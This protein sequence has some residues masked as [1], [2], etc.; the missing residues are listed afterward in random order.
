[1][2][3]VHALST[4]APGALLCETSP[5]LHA[6]PS[7]EGR[8]A[9]SRATR[10]SMQFRVRETARPDAMVMRGADRRRGT[11]PGLH[12]WPSVEGR[13]APTGF[14]PV[15]GGFADL[16]LRPLGYG[17]LRS[18]RSRQ[19]FAYG[20]RARAR[21][22]RASSFA[23]RNVHMLALR[24]HQ[25]SKTGRGCKDSR[26]QRGARGPKTGRP[27]PTRW[28]RRARTPRS[29][30][31]RARRPRIVHRRRESPRSGRWLRLR[32]NCR[33]R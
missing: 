11:S 2:R 28:S 29:P 23:A 33:C 15:N 10:S 21:F 31:R 17:A 5:G 24:D 25:G 9:R 4:R 20:K 19:Q 14:E 8:E 6:W 22:A 30:G 3:N 7:V 16:S 27:S 18:L 26:R 1:M 32:S 13:E 12:A